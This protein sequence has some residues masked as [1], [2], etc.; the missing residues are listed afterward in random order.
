VFNLTDMKYFVFISVKLFILTDMKF[1]V[2]TD[3][4]NFIF[5]EYLKRQALQPAGHCVIV[6]LNINIIPQ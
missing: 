1:Y 5:I 2:S 3:V 4:K 6:G